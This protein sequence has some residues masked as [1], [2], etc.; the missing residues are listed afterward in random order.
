MRV[1]VTPGGTIAGRATV[2]GDK[3]IAHRWLIAATV[4]SGTSR[5]AGLPRALDTRST[6]SCLG[7]LSPAGRPALEAWA[8]SSSAPDEPHGSTWN[9]HG[10]R[11][12]HLEV[13]GEGRD[14]LAEPD[15]PL[16]CG[17]SG[18]TMRLLSGLVA[19]A[20]FRSVL[21]GDLSLRRRPMERV[22][23]PLRA[24]GAHVTT[25]DGTPPVEIEGGALHAIRFEAEVPSAQVKGAVLLAAAGAEG[26][27]TVVESV[28]T[29]DHTERLLEAL[30]APVRRADGTVELRGPF[31]FPPIVG[32][33]PG[34]PSSAAFLAAA[35]VL[36]GGTLEIDG[37]GLNGSRLGWL[38]V[39]SR[40]R[41]DVD[42]TIAAEAIGEPLGS[43]TVDGASGPPPLHVSA[44][45]LPLVIDEVPVLAALAAH[46]SD[47]SRFEGGE[48]LRVKESDRLAA[49]VDGIRGL[50]G[51]AHVED[52][53]LVVAGGGLRGGAASATGDHRIAMALVVAALA[54]DGPC[55]IEGVEAADVSFPG[56]LP[57]LRSLGARIEEVP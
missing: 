6:A 13:E 41:V 8:S 33:V 2:P 24:M 49:L 25:T 21:V 43:L 12:E 50:G 27:T 37:V 28:A 18:T 51:D 38:D 45:G 26:T 11:V 20:P 29:R 7:R 16:D 9:R 34:D 52:D 46:A 56:F 3:S 19:A 17:N 57:T 15:G 54:A 35:A 47:A 23:R 1:R 55:E 32:S 30:G 5:I 39:L 36:T 42:G 14:V 44:E 48:E 53:D 4:A 40:Y 22:A 10:S 31:P